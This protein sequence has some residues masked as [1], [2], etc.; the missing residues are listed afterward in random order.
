M[1]TMEEEEDGGGGDY[2]AFCFAILEIFKIPL[3]KKLCF[4]DDNKYS[5]V[6]SI[7]SDI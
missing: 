3:L 6:V 2:V 4:V 7:P 1:Y 5:L